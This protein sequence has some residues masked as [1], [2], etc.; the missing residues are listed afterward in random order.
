[1]TPFILIILMSIWSIYQ[2]L[3]YFGIIKGFYYVSL[4][5]GKHFLVTA[6]K[7]MT[8]KWSL[9]FGIVGVGLGIVGIIQSRIN[10]ERGLDNIKM[11]AFVFY[12]IYTFLLFL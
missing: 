9:V 7:M 1:M 3:G 5:S 6:M 2:Y 8:M 10:E 4:F 12:C 11:P